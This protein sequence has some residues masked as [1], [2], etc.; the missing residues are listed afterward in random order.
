M[1]SMLS[2]FECITPHSSL[3]LKE[4]ELIAIVNW[5]FHVS[6]ILKL[7]MMSFKYSLFE[8]DILQFYFYHHYFHIQYNC[9]FKNYFCKNFLLHGQKGS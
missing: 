5:S 4:I 2:L 3:S 9:C 1:S 8:Q 6:G 7:V